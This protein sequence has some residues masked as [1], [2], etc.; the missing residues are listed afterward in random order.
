MTDEKP[1]IR[2][3]A[4]SLSNVVA[5]LGTSRDKRSHNSFGYGFSEANWPE[6]ESAYTNNWIAKQVVNVPVDDGVREW[7]AWQCEEAADIE[8][9]EHRLGLKGHYK[10]AR[11]WARLYGGSI[12]LM[13]TDQ[14]L[15]KPLDIN[16]VKKGSLKRLVVLDRWDVS[17]MNFNYFSPVDANYLKPES[18]TVTG[19]ATQI[20]WSHVVR[21][22]GEILPRRMRAMNNGWGDSTLRRVMED[23]KDAVA[24][25]GGIASMV[26]ESNVDVITRDGLSN[27]LASGQDSAILQR[28][29]LAAQ[30][31][32]IV[33]TLLL[34][35]KETYERKSL[36]F[37]GLSQIMEQFM[38]WLSGAADIPMTRLFGRSAAGLSATGEGDLNNYYDSVRAQQESTFKQELA[39]LD[40]VMIR[41][42]L[43]Y[44]PDECSYE[45]RPLYQ[46]SGTELAQQ[47]LARAQAEDIRLAQGVIKPSQVALR[48]KD[49]GNYAITDEDIERMQADEDAQLNGEFDPSGS[50]DP[51]GITDPAEP[52]DDP[53][54]GEVS[55]SGK[56]D[57]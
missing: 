2:G 48:M 38:V 24:T 52:G 39:P 11:Y 36:A 43:G 15:D 41:S 54:A 47:D 19:G 35:G 17:P 29:G 16:K 6:M 1:R 3:T 51:F 5:N 31:K 18:Y 33:N 7:R 9:E 49:D 40:E 20:H 55:E 53:E 21:C 10:E 26:L 44:M 34:D 46:E 8:A 57:E 27:E 23:V 22:D 30:M 42:A 14:P 56:P 28:Y 50:D 4:D 13:V 12:V 25:K 32:S 45:W 37:S